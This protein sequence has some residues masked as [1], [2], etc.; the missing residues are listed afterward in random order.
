[1]IQHMLKG[2]A[3]L[4]ILLFGACSSADA[5]KNTTAADNEIVDEKRSE[6]SVEKRDEVVAENRDENNMTIEISV[7]TRKFSATL[8][9]NETAKSFAKKLPL[10]VSM[11][12]L[13]DNE[14]YVYLGE[15]LTKTSYTPKKMGVGDL[16]LYGND[17]IVIFYES[18]ENP[19][20]SYSDIGKIE[21]PDGLAAALKSGAKSVTFSK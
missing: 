4:S 14:Y 16:K 2:F 21:N 18:F 6:A 10:T 5:A 12:E 3:I 8:A 1:M 15:S 17:C 9:D 19:G 20:Y 13:H 11:S 7:G